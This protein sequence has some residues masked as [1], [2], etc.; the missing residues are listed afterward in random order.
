M[1]HTVLPAINT[2]IGL[3]IKAQNDWRDVRRPSSCNASPP[4]LVN[5]L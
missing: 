3:V 1:D 2:I 5:W 4:L